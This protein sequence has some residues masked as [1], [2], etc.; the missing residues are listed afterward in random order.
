M[1]QRALEGRE[2][3]LGNEHP[4]TLASVNRLGSVFARQGMY[5][6]AEAMH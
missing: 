1:H 3:V 6:K 2:K 4:D 5:I